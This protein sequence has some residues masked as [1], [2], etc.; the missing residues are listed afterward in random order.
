MN[1]WKHWPI[2][3]GWQYIWLF[4][5]L[6][7][8]WSV[9]PT[10][11]RWPWFDSSPN[12]FIINMMNDNFISTLEFFLLT[13]SRLETKTK[14]ELSIFLILDSM[15]SAAATSTPTP[16][17]TSTSTW[18]DTSIEAIGITTKAF[19]GSTPGSCGSPSGRRRSLVFPIFR[20]T[21]C[22]QKI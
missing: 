20:F 3:N 10:V 2:L 22:H 1:Q 4:D 13:S 14:W 6:I 9:Q 19:G 21:K 12:F 17:P 7:A 18:R 15:A 11:S 5:F 8:Q 16:T